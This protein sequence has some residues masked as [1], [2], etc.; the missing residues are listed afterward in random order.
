MDRDIPYLSGFPE[1]GAIMASLILISL[2][3]LLIIHRKKFPIAAFGAGWLIIAILPVSGIIPINTAVAEHYLYF[4]AIGF[5][6]LIVALSRNAFFVI[7]SV[8][9]QSQKALR[10]KRLLRHFPRLR[11]EAS[12]PRNDIV[13]IGYAGCI[14]VLIILGLLTV[15]RNKEWNNPMTLYETSVKN[16]EYSFRS[17]NNLGVEYFRKGDFKTAR[18]YFKRSLQINPNY[19]PA[20]NNMGVIIQREGRINNALAL[21]KKSKE[22]DPNYLL[23]YRN[24]AGIYIKLNRIEEAKRELRQILAIFPYDKEAERQLKNLL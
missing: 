18:Y 24:I 2:I 6:I 20:L 23:A 5:F 13:G 3:S 8:A 11:R 14:L 12:V 22:N 10:N 17:N 7:A 4:P 21:F 15:K 1:A 19:A 16:A 9:K